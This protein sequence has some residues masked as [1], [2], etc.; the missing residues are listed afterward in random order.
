[1]SFFENLKVVFLKLP[2][3]TFLCCQKTMDTFFFQGVARF[4]CAI[5]VARQ[6]WNNTYLNVNL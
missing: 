3:C 1:M 5:F 2:H 4:F 6:K